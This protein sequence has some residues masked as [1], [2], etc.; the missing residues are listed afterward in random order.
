MAHVIET[1]ETNI[2][3]RARAV[4]RDLIDQAASLSGANRSQFMLAS[5]IEK[6]KSVLLDQTTL[7]ANVTEF[8]AIMDILDAPATVEQARGMQRLRNAG[9]NGR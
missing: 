4:D 6:A 8:Q 3:L 2:H 9:Q 1:A 7:L 5:A